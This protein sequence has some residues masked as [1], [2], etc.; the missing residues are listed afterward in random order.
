MSA[1]EV[2]GQTKGGMHWRIEDFVLYLEGG[3]FIAE[4]IMPWAP[5][6][7]DICWLEI[8]GNCLEIDSYAFA[9]CTELSGFDMDGI[10]EIG[11]GAFKGCTALKELHLP[12]YLEWLYEDAFEDCTGLTSVIFPEGLW[13]LGPGAF[14]WCTN[15]ATVVIGAGLLGEGSPMGLYPSRYDEQTQVLMLSDVFVGCVSLKTIILPPGYDHVTVDI[16]GVTVI[17]A[18]EERWPL[19]LQDLPDFAAEN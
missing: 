5:Y 1:Q 9:D 10:E 18:P 7:D 15:L 3:D 13:Q 11:E 16:E 19:W 12:E 14:G 8:T 4:S 17:S 6:R 2:S